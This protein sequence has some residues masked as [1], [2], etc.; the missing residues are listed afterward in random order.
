[1]SYLISQMWVCLLLAALLGAV[2]GYWLT[3]NSYHSKLKQSEK[4]WQQ[5]LED[6]QKQQILVE[7]KAPKT[8]SEKPVEEFK[9]TAQQTSYDVEEVE[10]IG[11]NYGKKLR[12]IG[13]TTTEQLLDKCCNMDGQIEVANYVGIEDFVIRKWASMSDLMRI[14]GVEGQCSELMVYAGIESVQELAQQEASS[15]FNTL[16]SSNAEQHRVKDIPEITSLELMIS[17]AK[18]LPAKMQDM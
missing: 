1:M 2:F 10:G 8:I 4:E 9:S 14:S 16:S 6:I 15:L 18:S 5:K 3:K 12:D 13:I 17:Q 11:Q 7:P